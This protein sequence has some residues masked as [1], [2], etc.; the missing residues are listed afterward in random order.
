M[1]IFDGMRERRSKRQ[2]RRGKRQSARQTRRAGRQ[3]ARQQRKQTRAAGRYDP[4]VLLA[5]TQGRQALMGQAMDIGASVAGGLTGMDLATSAYTGD[6]APVD[7]F[8]DDELDD[9]D[10]G[11]SMPMIIGGIVVIAAVAFVAMKK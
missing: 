4:E 3:S 8:Y 7:V 9:D 10:S 5:R 11:F 2:R 6:P 1:G